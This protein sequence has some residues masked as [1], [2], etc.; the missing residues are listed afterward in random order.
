MSGA[1]FD[2]EL[3]RR[4]LGVPFGVLG[5]LW[6]MRAVRTIK[7]GAQSR[8]WPKMGAKVI[9]LPYGLNDKAGPA[10][11]Y[12]Y[13]VSGKEY[14]GSQVSFARTDILGPS[15]GLELGSGIQIS[16]DPGDPKNSVVVPGV[17]WTAYRDLAIV[18]IVSVAVP[19]AW[20]YFA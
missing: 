13:M 16:V 1:D 17:H 5:L 2:I 6:A 9:S 8:H 4:F 11:T 12:S 20:A 7:L 14:I 18:L 3:L 10:F 19:V 15:V